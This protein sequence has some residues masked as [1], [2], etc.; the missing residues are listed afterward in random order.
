MVAGSALRGD[1]ANARE[2]AA[3]ARK[4]HAAQVA[5]FPKDGYGHVV[6]GLAQAYLGRHAEA[7]RDGERGI[8]LSPASYLRR[9]LAR[10][11]ILAG[12]HERA[13]DLLEQLLKV[14]YVLTPA[15]LRIDP[16]FDPLRGNPRFEKL[17]R[18][19]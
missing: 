11:H 1:Q 19:S 18:G 3:V 9:K 12:N 8:A 15:W 6:L 14:P 10:I 17:A 16:S 2:Y 13:I 5:E 7:V 4:A